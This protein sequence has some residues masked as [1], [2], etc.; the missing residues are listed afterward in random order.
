[1]DG[2][3]ELVDGVRVIPGRRIPVDDESK[4]NPAVFKEQ[5]AGNGPHVES[6]SIGIAAL[7]IGAYAEREGHEI[8]EIT[9]REDATEFVEGCCVLEEVT[10]QS[11][12]IVRHWLQTTFC[13]SLTVSA[14]PIF[15]LLTVQRFS[16]PCHLATY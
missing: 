1:M 6:W 7:S 8:N 15:C 10:L 3:K 2:V 11:A 16:A 14:A 9:Q 13:P 12:R 5:A 4:V